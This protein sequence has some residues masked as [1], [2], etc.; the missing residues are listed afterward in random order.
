MSKM[1]YQRALEDLLD[2][3][4]PTR[5]HALR[6]L[7]KLLKLKNQYALQNERKLFEIFE[8]NLRHE[9]T[10]I[11]LA[12]V[13]GLLSLVDAHHKTVMPLLCRRFVEMESDGKVIMNFF[14]LLPFIFSE[15]FFQC[16]EKTWLR[17]KRNKFMRK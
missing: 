13:D 10:Y 14:F 7:S 3:L 17:I 4:L 5:G 12:A 16:V 8:K 6:Q 1:C 15:F 9:D 11:Y 2:P